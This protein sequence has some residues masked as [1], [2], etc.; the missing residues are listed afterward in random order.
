MAI[1]RATYLMTVG[2]DIDDSDPAVGNA[3]TLFQRAH[4]A[5]ANNQ[6]YLAIPSPTQAQAVAQ[7]AAL[8]RQVDGVIRFLLNQVRH[9][10]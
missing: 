3:I 9:D 8:T 6:T 5:L 1:V 2:L 7:V 10:R 4:T